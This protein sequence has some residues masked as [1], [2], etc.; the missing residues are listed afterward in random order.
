MELG[1]V[2]RLAF[3]RLGLGYVQDERPGGKKKK[4]GI[5]QDENSA[6]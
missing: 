4:S 6:H 2:I 1:E 3:S 5:K